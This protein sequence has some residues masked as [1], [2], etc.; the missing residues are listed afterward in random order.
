MVKRHFKTIDLES[1]DAATITETVIDAFEE[2]KIDVKAKL[3]DVGMDG[4]N[5]MIGG[6]TGA[7][8]RMMEEIP[9]L[10]STGSCNSHNIANA[11]K[12]ATNKFNSDIQQALV[13]V[14]QDIGGARGKG[15]KNKKEYRVRQRGCSLTH[16]ART[17][18]AVHQGITIWV[19]KI[20]FE[21]K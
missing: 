13:D 16:S 21:K 7:I 14:Y 12:H 20:E 4:C 18:P 15:F 11:M 8:T 19:D 5:T 9:E 17:P 1:G 3:I 10:S 2:E 6:K